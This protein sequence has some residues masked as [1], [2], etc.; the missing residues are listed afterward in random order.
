MSFSQDF[1][2]QL[3]TL[4]S[5]DRQEVETF[6]GYLKSR[7]QKISEK[8]TDLL[9]K[10]NDKLL[11]GYVQETID[12]LDFVDDSYVLDIYFVGRSR[13][14]SFDTSWFRFKKN[15]MLFYTDFMNLF[16]TLYVK[17]RANSNRIDKIAIPEKYLSEMGKLEGKKR[18]LAIPDSVLDKHIKNVEIPLT[19]RL[20]NIFESNNKLNVNWPKP[21]DVANLITASVSKTHEM[22]KGL[23][24]FAV[25]K[26]RLA[27]VAEI[28]VNFI[29]KTGSNRYSWDSEFFYG[30]KHD[31]TDVAGLLTHGQ[32]IDIKA[33]FNS[34]D[35]LQLSEPTIKNIDADL[36][37]SVLVEEVGQE[38]K[39]TICGYIPK[40][41]FIS[42]TTT[43][44]YDQDL[45][46]RSLPTNKLYDANVLFE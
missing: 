39:A 4:S 43:W 17:H 27:R 35:R 6:V 8:A 21:E 2:K 44:H 13:P 11:E 29:D 41:E 3:E 45:D 31:F 9:S 16:E 24:K 25:G 38:Y 42:R 36:I 32:T 26:V 30:C 40:E 1:L 5:H 14:F 19:E 33:H 34:N 22:F 15:E 12:Y 23:N 37:L 46:M 7:P 18:I 20:S 10:V 28:M